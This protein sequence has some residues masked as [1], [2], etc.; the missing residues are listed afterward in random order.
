MYDGSVNR[1]S[2]THNGKKTTFVPLSLKYVFINHCKLEKKRQEADAK[3]EIKK[4]SSEKKSLSEKQ[5]SSAQPGE[6]KERKAKS[7][8]LYVLIK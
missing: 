6:K 2:F 7:V 4:E 3:A 5:E 1:Y 8:S